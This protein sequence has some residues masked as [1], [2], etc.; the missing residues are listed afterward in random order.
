V[1]SQLGHGSTFSF[2][3]PL[4][5]LSKLVAPILTPEGKLPDPLVLITIEV[6][7]KA[8]HGGLH[9]S[10][11]RQQCMDILRSCVSPD[12]DVV[13]PALSVNSGAEIFTVAAHATGQGAQILLKR[14]QGQF[15]RCLELNSKT[16][17]KI[18]AVPVLRSEEDKDVPLAQLVQ[19]LA[20]L[21]NRVATATLVQQK[22]ETKPELEPGLR[23]RRSR[24]TATKTVNTE[25][26]N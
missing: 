15:E 22:R 8:R 3:L 5:S 11:L 23:L 14:I 9:W 1:E 26:L 16:N 17:V 21:L 25:P 20:E 18:S 4:F 12:K 24:P 2:T 13:L 10:S 7:A 6:T 19:Q